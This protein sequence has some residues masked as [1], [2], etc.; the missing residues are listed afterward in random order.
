MSTATAEQSMPDDGVAHIRRVA[1]GRQFALA[2]R[3]VAVAHVSA[4]SFWA[5]WRDGCNY[6]LTQSAR[7]STLF[8]E[9][10]EQ[11]LL[12]AQA[13]SAAPVTCPHCGEVLE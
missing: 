3:D 11:I 12:M 8:S 10:G 9:V 2:T 6:A 4:G 5:I 1:E 7:M 13:R